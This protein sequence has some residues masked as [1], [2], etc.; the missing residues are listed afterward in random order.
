VVVDEHGNRVAP[1]GIHISDAD[2]H[3]SAVNSVSFTP[4][5][6]RLAVA[7]L[8]ERTTVF[9]TRTGKRVAPPISGAANA[10]YSPDGRLLV[11]AAFNGTITFYDASTLEP[12]GA[13]IVGSSAW[14]KS[15]IF[16]SDSRLLATVSLDST[17]RVFDVQA[18]RQLGPA[19]PAVADSEA[20]LRP[21]GLALATEYDDPSGLSWV[22]V[23][24]LDPA[25]WRT[26]ACDEAG[27]N[28]T[29]AEWAQYLGGAYH[30]TC[31]QWPGD[32]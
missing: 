10:R 32:S 8:N 15:L 12:D 4:D 24:N 21:D 25:A 17:A 22:Q 14:A 30:A 1:T 11:T 20:S 18:R 2:G 16:S 7:G 27:R 6:R 28:L 13:P 3:P 31:A 26:A 29:R 23:W 19:L 5:G 9:D